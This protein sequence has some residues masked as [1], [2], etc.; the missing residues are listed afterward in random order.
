MTSAHE[1]MTAEELTTYC[2]SLLDISSMLGKKSI[3][4]GVSAGAVI[5]AW[6][7]HMRSEIA[8]VVL[9]TPAFFY[10]DL[11][12]SNHFMAANMLAAVPNVYKWFDPVLKEEGTSQHIYPRYATH[13]RA[14]FLRLSLFVIKQ[15][16]KYQPLTKEYIIITNA[17]EKTVD[18]TVTLQFI[19]QLKK[20]GV[21]VKTY[22]FSKRLQ[23]GSDI[24]DPT[25]TDEQIDIVYPVIVEMVT[26]Q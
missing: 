17:N 19:S 18:N 5:A 2:D 25:R 10:Q 4:V 6:A 16:K 7:A 9:I 20:H 15:N 8:S 21:R 24:I 13:A 1:M 23:L 22:E 3:L 26:R 12:L 11:P 14:Q